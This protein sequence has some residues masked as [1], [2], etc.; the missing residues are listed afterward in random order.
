MNKMEKQDGQT[1]CLHGTYVCT[2]ETVKKQMRWSMSDS[3]INGKGGAR[4]RGAAVSYVPS[5]KGQ[6]AGGE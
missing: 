3:E 1:L 6:V 5:Q 2:G 4:S